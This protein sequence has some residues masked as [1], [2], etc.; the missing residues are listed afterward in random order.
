MLAEQ[1]RNEK[2]QSGKGNLI[3]CQFP[4]IRI[5]LSAEPQ[6]SGDSGH[7]RTHEVIQVSI[8]WCGEFKRTKIRYRTELHWRPQ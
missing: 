7:G 3:H 2:V 5:E 6:T 1:T 4:E 8:R